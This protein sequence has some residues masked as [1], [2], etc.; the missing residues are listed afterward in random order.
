MAHAEAE[1]GHRLHQLAGLGLQAVGRRSALLHQRR[2]LLR[3]LVHLRDG[4]AH[5]CPRPELCSL[6][7]GADLAHDVRH[8]ADRG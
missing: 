3:G 7:A 8:A 6:L 5:L 4:L 1:H 2:V